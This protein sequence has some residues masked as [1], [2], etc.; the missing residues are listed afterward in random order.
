MEKIVTLKRIEATTDC[1]FKVK[2][3]KAVQKLVDDLEKRAYIT[4]VRI[5][6]HLPGQV[7]LGVTGRFRAKTLYELP[8]EM[9]ARFKELKLAIDP[10]ED[11]E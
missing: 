7:V 6:T 2:D 10:P 9:C 1:L 3:K 4:N 8:A 11:D 5:V